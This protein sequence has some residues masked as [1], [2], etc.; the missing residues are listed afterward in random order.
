MNVKL[1]AIKLE[2]AI[3][4]LQHQIKEDRLICFVGSGISKSSGLPIWDV[5]V[6]EFIEFCSNLAKNIGDGE[7]D[8]IYKDALAHNQPIETTT[9]LKE[10]LSE[11]ARTETSI[12]IDDHFKEWFVEL[13]TGA[14]PNIKHE[15]IISSNYQHIVT[16][17]YDNLLEKAADKLGF[18][19][20]RLHSFSYTEANKIAS[21]IHLSERTIIHVHGKATNIK[22]NQVVLTINDYIKMIKKIYPGFTFALQDLFYRYSSLFL[23]YGASDPHLEDLLQELSYFFDFSNNSHLPVHYLVVQEKKINKIYE[24][25]KGKFHTKL[26]IGSNDFDELEAQYSHL[27]KTL[28]EV[29]P[30]TDLFPSIKFSYPSE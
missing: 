19:K 27:L 11:K 1:Q 28:Y 22:I 6:T 3:K 13:F 12:S 7:F 8:K 25:Y 20:L 9:V 4:E 26:I 2:D 17:N 5:F 10:W 29:K 18:S 23:G 14:E 24:T 21:A 15:L 30:L 16:S